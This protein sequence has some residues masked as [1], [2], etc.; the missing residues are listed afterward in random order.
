MKQ[1]VIVAVARTPI[2][3]ANKGAFNAIKSPTLLGHAIR[4][5]VA[6]SRVDPGEV[7]DVVIGTVLGAGTAGMNLA[8]NAALAAGLGVGASGQTIDRQCA[9]GLMAIATAAK[10]II[11]DGMRVVVAGG[12]ENI[13][14]VQKGY[15]EWASAEADPAVAARAPHAYMPMLQTAEFVARKYCIS[16]EAQ[17]AYALQSQQRT[18]AAQ[19]SG[20]F[21]AEI[22][23]LASR[24][25]VL[26]KASGQLSWRD[27]TLAQDEGNRPET[28]A[29]SLAALKPV[30]EGGSITAGNA[31]QL[32]DGAAACVLMDEA[33]AVQRGLA[34][35]GVCRGIAVA[36][37]VPEEMGI[38]PV[39][40][41][42][43]LLKQHGLTVDDIGLW[44]LNE[45]FAC[46]ALY[47]RDKLGIDPERYNVDGGGISVGHPYGMT[48]AR[49]VG[50][51]LIEGR[52]RGERY[53]VVTM[54][55]GGGMGAAGL[56][57]VLP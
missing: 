13:S 22:V 25:A 1:A 35:L 5:A 46:Q 16:R 47:C 53:V 30:I 33:L 51:A 24:M 50:H 52:R 41:V 8:R 57:E 55:V 2:G 32:S 44:E 34:P 39:L 23:P 56:F 27:V 11:V 20:K 12:Q 36:G 43:K 19:Q 29:A 21:D 45:A 54:C 49:L 40:A 6:R 10:Q 15:F 31:S 7:D 37:L 42:P 9:S 14:A 3:R 48:G 18:A 28:T 38:G 4:H 17:D 26:D